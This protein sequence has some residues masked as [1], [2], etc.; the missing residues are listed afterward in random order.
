MNL[1]T[2]NSNL[3]KSGIHG[4]GITPGVTCPGCHIKCYAMRGFYKVFSKN[5]NK[6]W[7]YKL[8]ATRDASFVAEMYYQ[9]RDKKAKYVRIHTEGDFYS[10]QYLNKWM[11]I[12]RIQPDVVFYAYTKRLDLNFNKLPSNMRI[13]QSLGGEHDA[14]LDK[15]KPHAVVFQTEADLIAAGYENCTTDDM[16]AVT[17]VKVGLIF[18]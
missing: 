2:Q 13:I 12:A 16:R 1:L 4:F 10:Q 11:S 9:I 15:S 8:R 14:L 6:A 18:H 17:A 5:C 3:K 7:D